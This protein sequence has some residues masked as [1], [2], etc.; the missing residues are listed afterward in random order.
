MPLRACIERVCNDHY[1]FILTIAL[2]NFKKMKITKIIFP[3]VVVAVA[4]SFVKCD[5]VEDPET[6][7]TVAAFD[8]TKRIALIEEWTGHTCI[9][10]PNA[11]R[12]IDT[13]RQVYGE[14]FVAISIHDGF[15]AWS[16][17]AG[18]PGC[19]TGHPDAFTSDFQCPTAA[20][21][22]SAHSSGPSQP[23]QGMMNRL[24]IPSN[25][26]IKGRGRWAGHVDSII[27]TNAI[28]SIHIDH[29][30]NASTR[31]ITATVRGTWLMT[32]PNNLNVAIMLTESGMVGWQTD[33][34]DC[35]SEFVFNDVLR[36]CLNTPGSISGTSLT[37]APTVPGTTYAYTLST[38]YTLPAAFDEAHCHLIAIIYDTVTG[39]AMQAWEEDL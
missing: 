34:T 2:L 20:S 18:M 12:L 11:A 16:P 32:H 3:A 39:E 24:G 5:Y 17:P 15:F 13:L 10:C 27:Q 38:P 28:C 22:T 8:T 26:E 19:A 4:L 37:S 30:Y 25:T 29:N 33:G 7:P 6:M 36:E 23:P 14:R 35:D 31:A 1:Q 9:A 21:Y